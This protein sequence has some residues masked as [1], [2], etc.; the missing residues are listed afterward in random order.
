MKTSPLICFVVLLL[1]GQALF[2][3]T[4][5]TVWLN[6]EKDTSRNI[7]ATNKI[8]E[9]LAFENGLS[10]R[11][12]KLGYVLNYEKQIN[13]SL[14]IKWKV[15][16]VQISGPTK[17]LGYDLSDFLLPLHL[18]AYIQ[19][20][21]Y[22]IISSQTVNLEHDT[23]MM[24]FSLNGNFSTDSLTLHFRKACLDE[25]V[26]RQVKRVMDDI[27]IY[28]GLCTSSHYLEDILRQ[29]YNPHNP[30][31]SDI[32][33][34]LIEGIRVKESLDSILSKLILPLEKTDPCSLHNSLKSI[35]IEIYRHRLA[36]ERLLDADSLSPNDLI[37]F[38]DRL[39][40]L[41]ISWIRHEEFSNPVNNGVIAEV[42]RLEL[43]AKWIEMAHELLHPVFLK[44]GYENDD[45]LLKIL[46]RHLT[47]RMLQEAEALNK[48]SLF[49]H[50]N[51]VLNNAL[52]IAQAADLED[53][54]QAVES[55]IKVS[56][57]GLYNTYLKVA[58]D[59]ILNGNIAMGEFYLKKALDYQSQNREILLGSSSSKSVYEIFADV[60]LDK[61]LMLN[62][63]GK[64]EQA[65]PFLGKAMEYAGRQGIYLRQYELQQTHTRTLREIYR[66]KV[67]AALSS[68]QSGN[69]IEG[70]SLLDEALVIKKEN[71]ATILPIPT[72]D[73]AFQLYQK[74]SFY[75]V[76]DSLI[77]I[78]NEL[79]LDSLL[80][81]ASLVLLQYPENLSDDSLICKKKIELGKLQFERMMSSVGSLLWDFNIEEARQLWLDAFEMIP[82]WNLQ[83]CSE[84]NDR[85][86]EMA[87]RIEIQ[88]CRF[89]RYRLG[90][91]EYEVRSA[92]Q[93]GDYL[94]GDSLADSAMQVR[95]SL[96]D[97]PLNY[98]VIT[99]LRQ[100]YYSL[101]QYNRL[102]EQLTNIYEMPPADSLEKLR[103]QLYAIHRSDSSVA[104]EFPLPDTLWLVA[105]YPS[106]KLI[107]YYFENLK[108]E[109]RWIAILKLMEKSRQLGLSSD[110]FET[111]QENL[112]YHL[113]I[114]DEIPAKKETVVEYLDQMF[115][116]RE[117][118]K[119]LRK[120]YLQTKLRRRTIF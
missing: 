116:E 113:A 19:H 39:F 51:I 3:G 110:L 106:E 5:D 118:Y 33:A 92:F 15:V 45:G 50:A 93:E 61:A 56:V 28:H 94:E 81:A 104:K 90:L 54:T 38:S 119:T 69:Y 2:A 27:K 87:E 109:N 47:K 21:F 71:T 74:A 9:E 103:L 76:M 88:E 25:D 59:G 83:D 115:P 11:R 7:Q 105:L 100:Q 111:W 40:S 14:P 44:M 64:Y 53:E 23:V 32:L 55:Q 41:W 96:A 57:R 18:E 78:S 29:G 112:G 98:S 30:R 63:E 82:Q 67:I 20:P 101:I 114:T 117:W 22:G 107:H 24:D 68:L 6:W 52:N 66:Q 73:S 72:E 37:S 79:S 46:S 48:Q 1:I 102:L 80:N 85:L 60:C 8:L 16:L 70:K 42:A 99:Q 17:Y 10:Y 13:D 97:C 108:E 34:E 36:L 58:L 75:F 26:E 12:I 65:L 89:A 35:D 120:A 62:K 49:T 86:N 43:H 4:Q 91:F 31:L 84:I 95:T 77:Q